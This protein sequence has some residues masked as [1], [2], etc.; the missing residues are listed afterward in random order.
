MSVSA[1][2]IFLVPSLTR[3][4]AGLQLVC[5]ERRKELGVL[6]RVHGGKCEE[7][8]DFMETKLGHGKRI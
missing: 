2:I 6:L 5:I 3:K 8:E 1:D 4:R 7:N